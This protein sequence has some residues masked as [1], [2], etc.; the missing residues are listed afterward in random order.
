MSDVDRAA[1]EEHYFSCEDC[2][3][4]VKAAQEFRDSAR[5]VFKEEAERKPKAATV[6][7]SKWYRSSVVPWTL[8]ASLAGFAVYQSAGLRAVPAAL[9]AVRV[10][11]PITLRPDSRGQDP[12]VVAGADGIPV[13]FEVNGVQQGADIAF[14]IKTEAGRQVAQG[15]AEARAAGIPLMLML[16]PDVLAERTRYVASLS[17]GATGQ[18]LG[19]YR[20]VRLK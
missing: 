11:E 16:S 7:Y 3:Q 19:D 10:L 14:T 17:E 20:F 18:P 6:L 5:D 15:H 1:F 8:A 4:D 9:P 12:V 13:F 2:A